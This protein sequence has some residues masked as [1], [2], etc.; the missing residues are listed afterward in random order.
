LTTR[1][2]LIGD[3]VEDLG[4]QRKEAYLAHLAH[5]PVEVRLVSA[6]DKLHNARAIL[7]DYRRLGEPLWARFTGS[8]D[9][10]L[11]YYRSLVT[12]LRDAGGEPADLV[13]RLDEVVAAL[14]AE[15]RRTV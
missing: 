8:R 13:N 1:F 12:A 3:G 7:A 11:W 9:E 15:V 10:Q 6:A 5:A 14:E 4:R 2:L